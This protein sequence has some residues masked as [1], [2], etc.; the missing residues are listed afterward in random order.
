MLQI[1]MYKKSQ[2]L[3]LCFVLSCLVGK[4]TGTV[5]NGVNA[6]ISL[7][8]G[9]Y[10]GAGV[11]AVAMLPVVGDAFKGGKM[12]AKGA[13]KIGDAVGVAKIAKPLQNHHFATIYGENAVRLQ[14]EI[15]KYGLKLDGDWNKE[16]LP[17]LGRHTQEY[18]DQ[19]LE[20]TRQA[21]AEAERCTA[22][23]GQGNTL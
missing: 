9:D 3:F 7:L 12:V 21:A 2:I 18:H 8:R 5:A 4:D 23:T 1:A 20:R 14:K 19:V 16:I 11:N 15:D 22:K 10:V 17:H 13:D 6:G